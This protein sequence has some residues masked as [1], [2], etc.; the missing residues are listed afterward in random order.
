VTLPANDS[1]RV[2]LGALLSWLDGQDINRLMVEGGG[3]VITSFLRERLANRLVMTVA[4]VLAGGYR[5]V[6]DL[7]VAHWIDLPRLQSPLVEAA[8]EDLIVWGE[9]G[10]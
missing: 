2:S 7:G 1:G 3:E 10:S 4:P 9:L 6:G 5:A 8:G